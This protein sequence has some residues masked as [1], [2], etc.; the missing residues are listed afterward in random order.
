MFKLPFT[1]VRQITVCGVI[2]SVCVLRF[3]RLCRIMPAPLNL[4][5]PMR[6]MPLRTVSACLQKTLMLRENHGNDELP[7]AFRGLFPLPC[8]SYFLYDIQN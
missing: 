2:E 3:V 8:I 7:G 1:L 6:R 4:A 5:L